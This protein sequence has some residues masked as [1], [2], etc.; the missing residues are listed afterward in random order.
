MEREEM[1]GRRREESVE[2]M[3]RT[4]SRSREGLGRKREKER[5]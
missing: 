3:A 2:T 5:T 4:E 1:R